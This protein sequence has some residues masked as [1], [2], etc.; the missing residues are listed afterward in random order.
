MMINR[1]HWIPP[2]TRFPS[3]LCP[4]CHRGILALNE[5]T[6]KIIETGESKGCHSHEAWEPDWIDERFAALLVCQSQRC[7]EIVA[8]GGRTYHTYDPDWE[9]QEQN[10][11]REFEPTLIY[12]APPV[13][14]M[15]QKC[16]KSVKVELKRAFSLFWTDTG[17]CAN[18]LRAAVEALLTDRK[19]PRSTI[20]KTG[21]R[22]RISL[23]AR[24]EKF[25]QSDEGSAEYLLAIK[26]HW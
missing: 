15:P 25:K 21:K 18:R 23:H 5:E 3:W 2:F 17:A 22:E 8:I 6:L 16:P 24:I 1:N 11:E 9:N 26:W 13:I 4:K 14:P 20:N 10:W 7:G 19:I 12:P